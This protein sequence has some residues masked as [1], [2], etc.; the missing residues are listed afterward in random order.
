VSEADV[1]GMAVEAE[2]SHQYSVTFCCCVTDAAEGQ[3]DTMAFDMEVCMKQTFAIEFL[4]MEK[5]APTDIQ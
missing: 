4:H 5:R 3:S 2:S 1:G